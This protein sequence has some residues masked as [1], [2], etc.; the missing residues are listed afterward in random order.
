MPGAGPS[1]AVFR[2]RLLR[3]GTTGPITQILI[4]IAPFDEW[5]RAWRVNVAP[6][7]GCAA[8]VA[9]GD[10]AVGGCDWSGRIEWGDDMHTTQPQ[11]RPQHPVVVAHRAADRRGRNVHYQLVPNMRRAVTPAP[12]LLATK[13]NP[14]LRRRRRAA[15]VLQPCDP[16]GRPFVSRR[17]RWSHLIGRGIGDRRVDQ[18]I[19]DQLVDIDESHRG[20]V[21]C[22]HRAKL[23]TQT[24]GCVG[25]M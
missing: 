2:A 23:A 25:G 13:L 11:S 3:P 7:P 14:R 9:A 20:I 1:A 10:A 24:Q 21:G 16:G 22:A 12:S 4:E 18:P 8:V 15:E 5:A 6:C 19:Q 17:D